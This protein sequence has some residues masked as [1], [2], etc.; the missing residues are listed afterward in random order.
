MTKVLIIQ[1]T[2]EH[3][4]I[5]VF[6]ELASRE[7]IDLIVS[8]PYEGRKKSNYADVELPY[9]HINLSVKNSKLPF[10]E[11]VFK[12]SNLFNVISESNP[13]VIIV[14]GNPRIVTLYKL[15]NFA[16]L[17]NYK[18]IAWTKFDNTAGFL[19]GKIWR[20]FLDKWDSIVCYG[21]VS[22]K[23]I[24]D[25]KF[26]DPKNVFVAQNTVE[27][28]FT[29]HIE[30]QMDIEIKKN[31]IPKFNTSSLKLVTLGTLVKK[32]KFDM[33]I[34]AVNNLRLK[35]YDIQ[36]AI[37]GDGPERHRLESMVSSMNSLDIFFV[38][39]VAYGDDHLWLKA[40]DISIMGGAVGLAMNVS[41]SHGTPT[42]IP[43]EYGSDSELLI[44]DVNG[45]RFMPN[46]ISSLESAIESLISNDTFRNHIG[47]SAISTINKKARIPVMVD[48]LERV[49]SNVSGGKQI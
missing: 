35:G 25:M 11:E 44:H 39:R 19:K 20:H 36:L 34:S 43:D 5:P 41:M 23:E 1:R 2:F 37:V 31:V 9:Q 13:D 38:G 48:G 30:K 27:V 22:R 4:R 49:I 33:V 12:Y 17:N 16:K 28:D 15:F 14:E 7:D 29:N 8:F 21:E 10:I 26:T 3:Y 46:S 47:K 6:S 18:I 32:K 40:A 45:I 24:I 42:I